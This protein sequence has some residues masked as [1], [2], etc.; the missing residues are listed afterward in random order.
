[1]CGRFRFGWVLEETKAALGF[2]AYTLFSIQGGTH[3]E[4]F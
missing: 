4:V 3:Y 2:E 1:M